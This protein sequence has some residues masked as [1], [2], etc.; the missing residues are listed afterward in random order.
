VGKISDRV[1]GCRKRSWNKEAE[2]KP[3]A[4]RQWPYYMSYKG[5]LDGAF[6]LNGKLSG[7]FSGIF[8][9]QAAKQDICDQG[10][11]GHPSQQPLGAP[12]PTVDG[13]PVAPLL[14]KQGPAKE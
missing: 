6:F 2:W 7:Y 14:T 9:E 8:M 5:T 12:R 1:G 13:Q 11:I 10:L 3:H 4:Q